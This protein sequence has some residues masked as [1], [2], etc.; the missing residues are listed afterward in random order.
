MSENFIMSYSCGKDSNLA[1]YRMIKQ[2]YIPSAL[3]VTAD[4]ASNSWFHKVPKN[5]IKEVSKALNIPLLLIECDGKDYEKEFE[6]ALIRAKE[7][8]KVSSCVFGDIDLEHHRAWGEDRCKIA[9]IE[10]KFP[11]W[12][13]DRE[14]LTYEFIDSNFKA[15]IKKVRLEKLDTSFLGRELTKDVICEIVNLGSDACGENGEYHTFVFDGPI[16]DFKVKF[17][18]LGLSTDETFGFLNIDGEDNE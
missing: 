16:F 6:D 10:A 14:K 7:E 8:F 2:G 11:L 1:L 17:K 3:L 15:V 5:L 12:G 13:E 9:N 4:K 18:N